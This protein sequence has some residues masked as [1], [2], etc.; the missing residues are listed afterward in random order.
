M[1]PPADAQALLRHG[2]QRRG[3]AAAAAA[4]AEEADADEEDEDFDE[5]RE[6]GDAL[7]ARVRR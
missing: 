6:L 7:E 3:G 5:A 1:S 4:A 2:R